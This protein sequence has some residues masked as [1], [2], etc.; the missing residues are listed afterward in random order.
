M[1]HPTCMRQTL[2]FD[3]LQC[4]LCDVYCRTYCTLIL[5]FDIS[6]ICAI[7][8]C[9]V[10]EYYYSCNY[11]C[12]NKH[13]RIFD[14]SMNETTKFR[15]HNVCHEPRCATWKEKPYFVVGYLDNLQQRQCLLEFALIAR[16][17]EIHK[18]WRH[19]WSCWTILTSRV[20]LSLDCI[21]TLYP[22]SIPTD[23]LQ[24]T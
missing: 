8:L 24:C 14:I 20:S 22:S 11:M 16:V 7:N 21:T 19:M 12:H 17:L 2:W 6:I 4:K 5:Q 10:S 18:C 1:A 9:Q 15:L 23:D 13:Q 3:Q